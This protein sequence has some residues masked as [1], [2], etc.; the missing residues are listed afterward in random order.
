M[1]DD[2][3]QLNACYRFEDAKL[4]NFLLFL[5]CTFHCC[6]FLCIAHIFDGYRPKICSEAIPDCGE[7]PENEIINELFSEISHPL[8]QDCTFVCTRGCLDIKWNHLVC[9]S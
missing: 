1:I 9:Y 8:C 3:V 5:I 7:L 2:D 4:V 6:D